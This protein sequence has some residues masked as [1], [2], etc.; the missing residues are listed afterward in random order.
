MNETVL[1]PCPFCGGIVKARE[2]SYGI[3][4]IITCDGCKTKFI[5]PWYEAETRNDLY[6]AWNRRAANETQTN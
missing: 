1:K 4:G 5:I 3:A 6:N 2:A